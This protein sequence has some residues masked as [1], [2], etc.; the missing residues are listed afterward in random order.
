MYFDS[1]VVDRG[2]KTQARPGIIRQAA[3]A[4]ARVAVFLAERNESAVNAGRHAPQLSQLEGNMSAVVA[5]AD[6]LAGSCPD[7]LAVAARTPGA[8]RLDVRARECAPARACARTPVVLLRNALQGA[9]RRATLERPALAAAL[10]TPCVRHAVPAHR[11]V[12]VVLDAEAVLAANVGRN[13]AVPAHLQ[14][15]ARGTCDVGKRTTQ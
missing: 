7:E 12:V 14:C 11:G 4:P 13:M 8:R 1:H 10:R 3:G 2:S 9:S 15:E 5:A 6:V